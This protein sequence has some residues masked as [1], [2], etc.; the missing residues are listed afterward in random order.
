MPL[1]I[2]IS[3]TSIFREAFLTKKNLVI[4][5]TGRGVGKSH[6]VPA[7]SIAE[8]IDKPYI[9]GLLIRNEY[10]A[11]K[12]SIYKSF[13]DRVEELAMPNLKAIE[14]GRIIQYTKPDG[15]KNSYNGF[16]FKAS[17][18]SQTAKSKSLTGYNRAILEE[19]EDTSQTDFR[20]LR[21][22]LRMEDTKI[23]L[24]LNPPHKSHWVVTT[25]CN[26]TPHPDYPNYYIPSLKT[27]Y[28]D[29]VAFVHGTYKDNLDNLP[30]HTIEQYK[31]YGKKEHPDYDLD[32]YCTQILGLISEIK[33]G[34][35]FK[36]LQ[37]VFDIDFDTLEQVKYGLDFG[38]T[39]HC[40]MNIKGIK[41]TQPKKTFY[42]K[43]L[44]YKQYL[45]ETTLLEELQRLG[46]R[47][48]IEIIADNSRPELIIAIRNAGY[49][50]TAVDK[51]YLEVKSQ[52]IAMTDY[53]ITICTN[54]PTEYFYR[55]HNYGEE[56]KTNLE[57]EFGN[58][59]WQKSKDGKEEQPTDKYNHGID[60]CRYSMMYELKAKVQPKK[61]SFGIYI[62]K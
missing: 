32:Y 2:E 7:Y 43:L 35:I 24:L 15:R 16:G 39:D 13:E 47:K 38:F 3:K 8:M 29:K 5:L 42:F 17:S 40:A 23:Y 57:Y 6:R 11:V 44:L 21:D 33:T 51:K 20:K 61:E 1:N 19:A 56:Y 46:I 36:G 41:D 53:I 54:E 25:Y 10:E 59:Q 27:E 34:L 52:V 49:W 48:D 45:T 18:K 50:I 28:K 37:K 4:C 62:S 58:Y 31:N 9:R 60:S 26:L 14:T 22:S 55:Q 12:N 30:A